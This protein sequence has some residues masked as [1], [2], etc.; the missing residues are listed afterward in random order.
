M[1]L[2]FP[3]ALRKMWSGGEVQEWIDKELANQWQD[4]SSAPKGAT[5]EDPCKEHWILGI[6]AHGEQK[7]IRWCMEYPSE[8]GCWMFAYAPSDYIDGI[9][10]FHPTHWMPLFERPKSI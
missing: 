9:Q 10:E 5:A 2:S 6:N 3:T 7:V 4:I 1:K 8:K